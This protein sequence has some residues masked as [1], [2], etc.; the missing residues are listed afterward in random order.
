[1]RQINQNTEKAIKI[2]MKKALWFS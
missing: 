2:T 1:M